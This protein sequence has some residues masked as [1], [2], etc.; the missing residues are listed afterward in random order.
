LLMAERWTPE[1]AW[2]WYRGQPW[3]VGCNYTPSTA[4]NQLEM[5]Q[6]ET[7]DPETIRRELGWA[8]GLGFNTARVYLHDLVWENDAQGFKKR[9]NSFLGIASDAGIKP[10]FVFFDDC[11][12]TEFRAGKQPEPKPGVHNS[13]W[14]QSPGKRRVLDPST[15]GSLEEYVL[16]VLGAFRGDERVLMWDLYNEPGNNDLNES[17]LG[18]VEKAFTWAREA[19]P[20][21]PLTVGVWYDNPA[22]NE[23][24]LSLSDVVSFHNYRDRASLEAQI[25]E[26]KRRGR[27]LVCTEYMARARVSRFETH[28]PVFKREGVGCINWG[29]VSGRT[30]TIYPWGSPPGAPEPEEW[31]HDIFRGDGS[32]YRVEEVEFIRK[33]LGVT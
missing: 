18:L 31:F 17:S 13:G 19:D 6:R 12:N 5:W 11:W 25:R 1:R 8:R 14:V 3:L 32:P 2:A 23:L 24:Q 7:F 4:V 9:I 30:Q 27:P 28:L 21:H 16:G 22:L 33:T 29:L 15:W 20:V 26:L 10:V